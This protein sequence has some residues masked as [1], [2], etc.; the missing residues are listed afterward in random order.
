MGRSVVVTGAGNGIG[1]ATVQR[2]AAQGD[3][4]VAVDHDSVALEALT[5][6]GGDI[7]PVVGDVRN[8]S[9]LRAAADRAA[10][11]DGLAGWVNNAAIVRLSPLHAVTED[12]IAAILGVNLTA[13]VLGCQVAVQS[14][15]DSATPG[16]IVN[17]S[18][19]HGR[20]AF[21]GY[22]LYDTAK[23]GVEALT[24]NVCVEYGRL[25]IRCNALAPGAV[26]TG[27]VPGHDDPGR[28]R[29]A[30]L[31][32]ARSLSPMHRISTPAEI[33]ELVV[34]LLS[35]SATSI[36]G[37]VIGADNGMSA[38]L[39]QLLGQAAPPSRDGRLDRHRDAR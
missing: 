32:A 10:E 6:D 23:G 29:D 39:V 27:I 24:R 22:G 25:G 17:I 14:F 13:V 1:R 11:R 34:F 26:D 38:G 16:S 30:D 5:R 20:V 37:Q 19:V 33:A 3:S 15:L 36:N 2:L 31:E 9:I 8:L 21:P 12:D 28:D 18:S 4:I 35:G 7:V